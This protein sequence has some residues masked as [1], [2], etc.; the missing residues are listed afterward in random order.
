VALSIWCVLV[1]HDDMVARAP[2]RLW[3][4]CV[5]CGRETRGW[6]L[7]RSSSLGRMP[8]STQT[9]RVGIA[10]GLSLR[11]DEHRAAA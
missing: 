8:P 10:P 11:G 3:L 2:E 5:Q 6:R 1:G 9:S 7:T 4:R